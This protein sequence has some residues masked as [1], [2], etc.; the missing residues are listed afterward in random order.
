MTMDLELKHFISPLAI[1]F[2]CNSDEKQ[3][4]DKKCAMDISL[5]LRG[6]FSHFGNGFEEC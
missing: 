4:S 3:V 5:N 1:L 6:F 2:F